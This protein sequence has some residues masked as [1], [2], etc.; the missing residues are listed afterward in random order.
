MPE[1]DDDIRFDEARRLRNAILAMALM[2]RGWM[3]WVERNIPKRSNLHARRIWA[4]RRAR[5]L[6][7]NQYRYLGR[8]TW[9]ALINSDSYFT[10]DG[11]LKA[12]L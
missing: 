6:V 3:W 9:L 1:I 8:S 10:D 7:A 5:V 12:H 11:A 2:D 4:E